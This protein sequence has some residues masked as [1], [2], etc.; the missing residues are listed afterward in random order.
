MDMSLS[1]KMTKILAPATPA[2]F[3]ASKAMPAVMAPS[4]M[5]ATAWRLSPF[6]CAAMAMP[7]AAEMLVDECAVP[8]ASYS[9][10]LRRGKPLM[11]PSWRKLAMRSRRP[12]KILCG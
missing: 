12:V 5:M 7:K 1:F 10:S 2:L 11:P 6:C 8:K 9:L 4:P 3:S